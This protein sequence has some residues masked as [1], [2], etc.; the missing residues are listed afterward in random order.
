MTLNGQTLDMNKI[1]YFR[2]SNSGKSLC[3]QGVIHYVLHDEQLESLKEYEFW[4]GVWTPLIIPLGHDLRTIVYP[5]TPDTKIKYIYN[6]EYYF[7]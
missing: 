2:V 7:F 5:L 6:S 1:Q 4:A 3:P